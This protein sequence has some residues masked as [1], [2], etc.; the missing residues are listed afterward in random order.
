MNNEAFLAG[1]MAKTAQ[2]PSVQPVSYREVS[3][4][5]LR[6]KSLDAAKKGLMRGFTHPLQ[7]PAPV[8]G[9]GDPSAIKKAWQTYGQGLQAAQKFQEKGM[10]ERF[11]APLR[12][13]MQAGAQAAYPMIQ[14]AA[15]TAAANKAQQM[16]TS[17]TAGAAGAAGSN[18][19][20]SRMG[21]API[22]GGML[23]RV[24]LYYTLGSGLV[25][26]YQAA[27]TKGKSLQNWEATREALPDLLQGRSDL[28]ERAQRDL[29][30]AL[31]GNVF[32]HPVLSLSH[33]A[34]RTSEGDAGDEASLLGTVGKNLASTVDKDM[35]DY[36]Q[37]LTPDTAKWSP[38]RTPQYAAAYP[39]MQK[40]T[41]KE[42]LQA[43][44]NKLAWQPSKPAFQKGSGPA[45]LR[46]PITP[47]GS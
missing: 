5:S 37:T 6:S 12:R 4:A 42:I 31:A 28:P 30:Y 34:L 33:G 2:D 44:A 27:K 24:P 19:L 43:L 7:T 20:M 41:Y 22:R 10:P 17:A 14:A 45:Y 46:S 16:G 21:K 32:G 8:K 40:D 39:W 3:P 18:L 36:T 29:D 35:Q 11:A 23:A 13:Q 47:P 9:A 1:Y 15:A 26:A 25:D 38:S